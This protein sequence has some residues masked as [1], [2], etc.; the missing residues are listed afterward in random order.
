MARTRLPT[1]CISCIISHLDGD[2]TSLFRLLTVNSTFF[3]ATLP[4]LY[5][6]P[7]RTLERRD[8]KSV[9]RQGGYPS[10]IYNTIPAKRLLYLLLLSCRQADDLVPF[11]SVDWPEPLSPFTGDQPLMACYIDYLGDLDFDRW[12]ATLKQLLVEFD[13][14]M[15]QHAFRLFRL[16]FLDHHKGRVEKLA[17]PITHIEPYMD[18]IPHL[19]NLQRVRF[20]E[21][22]LEPP[23]EESSPAQA[24]NEGAPVV[25]EDVVADAPAVENEAVNP[26]A[27]PAVE[28]IDEP[29]VDPN[30]DPAPEPEA[31]PTTESVA[32]PVAEPVTEPEPQPATEPAE[33]PVVEPTTDPVHEPIVEPV[34]EPVA[35]VRAEE[36]QAVE[37]AATEIAAA[38]AVP[39]IENVPVISRRE[40]VTIGPMETFEEML[41]LIM[42]IEM[43]Y[44]LPE[45]AQVEED[46]ESDD[47]PERVQNG[48]VEAL[49]EIL[50]MIMAIDVDY[51]LPER[52]QDEGDAESDDSPVPAQDRGEVNP[53]I[54]ATEESVAVAAGEATEEVEEAEP[55]VALT[56]LLSE[57]DEV[58]IVEI[59]PLYPMNENDGYFEPEEDVMTRLFA[60]GR[61]TGW[62]RSR[63]EYDPEEAMAYILA[64]V[65]DPEDVF[66]PEAAMSDLFYMLGNPEDFGDA[67]EWGGTG[68]AAAAEEEEQEEVVQEAEVVQEEI[69]N[70]VAQE[71]TPPAPPADETPEPAQPARPVFDPTPNGV[72]FLKQHAALFGPG[73]SGPGLVEIEPPYAWIHPSDSDNIT[74]GSRYVDLLMAQATPTIIQFHSWDRFR[75]YIKDMPLDGVKRLRYFYEEWPEVDWDQVGLIKK[76]R[77]LEKF[78]SRIY[79]PTIFKFAIEEQQDRDIY[80]EMCRNGVA[81]PSTSLGG[82]RSHGG[83]YG[84]GED[85]VPLRQVHLRSYSDGHLL[86]VLED[87]CTAFK[88]TLESILCRLYV[89]DTSLLL[90]QFHD[91]PRLTFLDLRHDSPNSLINDASF[92][93]G[94]RNLKTLRLRDG[95]MEQTL[96]VESPLALYEPWDLPCLEELVLIGTTCDL[97][98]YGTLATCP[99]LQSIRLECIV[100][101]MGVHTVC[102]TYQEHLGHLSWNW[103][104]IMPRLHTLFLKG[105]PAHLFRPTLLHGCPKLTNVHLDVGRVPRSVTAARDILTNSSTN[106]TFRSP[107]RSLTLKGRWIMNESATIVG[108]FFQTWFSNVV[109]LKFE[110]TVFYDDR[111]MLDGL[112]SIPSLRKVFLCRQ[113]VSKY[114]AWKLGLEET[115]FKSPFEWERK[116]RHES[117]QAE[118]QRLRL[119]EKQKQAEEEE[120]EARAK[121][122]AEAE[123][124]AEARA[125]AKAVVDTP[126]SVTIAG[127]T[128]DHRPDVSVDSNK[129]DTHK[130][131]AEPT[132]TSVDR[133]RCQSVD[134]AIALGEEQAQAAEQAKIALDEETSDRFE[135][136]RCVYIFKGKRYH[137]EADTP[138]EVLRSL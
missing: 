29:I 58:A 95:N 80:L 17:I 42:A 39:E 94:C 10:S 105:R 59:G 8:E 63:P 112:Y 11:L 93:R 55:I 52:A 128:L 75:H 72:K 103:A 4:V 12:T 79:D 69:N 35:E 118:L 3:R 56:A 117:F 71:E 44:V 23:P 22:E 26:I 97:F 14:Q 96:T 70:V 25:A 138:Q 40:Q 86:P 108:S 24:V 21:D 81:G 60:E 98:N 122:D 123:A 15:E 51:D 84:P 114:D 100:P 20:Y 6:D 116:T 104:W 34:V 99:Q 5:R 89:S 33:D 38:P 136:L 45:R 101:D 18:L 62:V 66:E 27:D 74:Y 83:H 47:T 77:N 54:A 127:V 68:A 119:I 129:D 121:A 67:W 78:S 124:E 131:T 61:R 135:S 113:A 137:R 76:C 16:L 106:T 125:K 110:S 43:D 9:R 115:P 132:T 111:S 85:P 7:Y 28:P 120:K 64:L 32:E 88:P 90:K 133:V 13:T 134:S 87:I 102:E 46:A 1:E 37:V 49:E 57:H 82:G 31:E 65:G 91:M 2:L 36:Q 109:Y 19:K 73:L 107:V 48:S 50:D 126:A 41:D 92:L 30:S 53:I 130:S